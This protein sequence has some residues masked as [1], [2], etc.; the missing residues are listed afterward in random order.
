MK[1][2]FDM[3]GTIADLYAVDGWLN[4]LR[5]YDASPYRDAKPL[6]NLSTL[7]RLLNLVQSKGHE[8]GVISWCSK[9]STSDYDRAVAQ[10]KREWLATHLPSVEWDAILIV[11]YGTNKYTVCKSGILFDDEERNLKEW[12]NGCA[13]APEHIFECL[14]TLNKI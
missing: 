10:A 4:K 12:L 13:F 6:V 1:V 9:C 14:K 2:W 5:N 11:P 7:A 8:I 3:D